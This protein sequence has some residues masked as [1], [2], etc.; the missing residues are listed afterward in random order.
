MLSGVKGAAEGGGGERSTAK[1]IVLK[2]VHGGE[3][4]ADDLTPAVTSSRNPSP[5]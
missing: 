1:V 5:P 3:K 4:E 2:L